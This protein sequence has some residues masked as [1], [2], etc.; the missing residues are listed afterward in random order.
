MSYQSHYEYL[1][2][3]LNSFWKGVFGKSLEQMYCDGISAAHGDKCYQYQHTWQEHG[4]HFYHGCALYMLTYTDL[5]GDWPKHQSCQWVIDNY[6]KYKQHLAP[7]FDSDQTII[8]VERA[9][10]SVVTVSKNKY[11]DKYTVFVDGLP[12]H[13]YCEHEDVFRV[14]GQ[15]LNTAEHRLKKLQGTQ[16]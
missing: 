2:A 10:G 11:G 16:P 9:D 3:N 8:E 14:L 12:K 15:Y 5:L 13:P 6:D 1:D 4:I 7:V